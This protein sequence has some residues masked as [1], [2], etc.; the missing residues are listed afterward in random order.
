MML[1]MGM[2]QFDEETNEAHN[3]KSDSCRHG[4][5]LELFSIWLGTFLN[6]SDR[7]FGELLSRFNKLHNLIHLGKSVC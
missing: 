5:L 2:D 7:I 4:N 6:Q 1:L 3:G